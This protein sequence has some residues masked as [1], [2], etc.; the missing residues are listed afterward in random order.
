[1]KL[2]LRGSV[3]LV[4]A[5]FASLLIFYAR[6][7]SAEVNPSPE[8]AT[9]QQQEKQE[10]A[11][12]AQQKK[13]AEAKTTTAPVETAR[14]SGAV[15]AA[16]P[17]EAE[18]KPTENLLASAPQLYNAT[19]YSRPGRGA[20]GMGVRFGT[21]AADPKV[22]PFGTRVRLDA[23][24]YSG[25]YVVTDSGTAIR[26]RKIDI[27]LPTYHEACRFGRRNVKLTVLSYGGKRSQKR[28]R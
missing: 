7:L 25:E 9:Q 20:S 15:T 10:P 3:G 1:M 4:A 26:G 17:F 13:E 19:S 12:A 8:P 6:P 11:Q 14:L 2:F 28:A 18:I 16:A 27:W 23:G 5:L 21:I 22:L 24:Q